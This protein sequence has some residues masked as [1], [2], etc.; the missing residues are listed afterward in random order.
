L[1]IF[2]INDIQVN[3]VISHATLWEP[4][5]FEEFN[6]YLKIYKDPDFYEK[7]HPDQY[8]H[9]HKKIPWAS[10]SK[11]RH[12]H[13]LTKEFTDLPK[14]LEFLDKWKDKD[15]KYLTINH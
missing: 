4:T 5:C 6:E 10:V 7:T 15:K 11:Q 13:G 1:L 2:L 14:W 3:Q 9:L 12:P 8:L